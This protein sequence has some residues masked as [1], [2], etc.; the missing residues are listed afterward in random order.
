VDAN[1][2]NGL[3]TITTGC[4]GAIVSICG[5]VARRFV[6]NFD[7]LT[8]NDTLKTQYMGSISAALQSNT[9]RIEKLEDRIVDGRQSEATDAQR[10]ATTVMKTTLAIVTGKHAAVTQER[11]EIM[12]EEREEESRGGRPLRA[13]R[14]R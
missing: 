10:E 2:V 13:S 4:A 5:F 7:T 9:A 6:K 3:L 11:A 8:A 14:P 1:L 12:G